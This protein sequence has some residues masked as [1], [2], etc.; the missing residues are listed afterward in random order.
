[1]KKYIAKTKAIRFE[2]NNYAGDWV[3]EAEKRGLPNL[4][5]T[6]AALESY[7]V[8]KNIKM[9]TSQNIL[10][11]VEIESRYNTKLEQYCNIIAIEYETL[12]TIV[13]TMVTPAALTY[14]NEVIKSV[15][16][17]KE[18]Q[19]LLDDTTIIKEQAKLLSNIAGE[20]SGL[21]KTSAVLDGLTKKA[22]GIEPE[23]EKAAYI[24]DKVIP[25]MND[26]RSHCD[27]LEELVPDDL[28]PLPKYR[29]MLF[30]M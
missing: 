30:I 13:S 21:S 8:A 9:L 18:V 25:A 11:E 27:L 26:V 17:L 29:E 19:D 16:G 3:K 28:W 4:K 10:S 15:Q 20:L 22:D 1:L 14:Q 5:N 23:K 2:G 7:R 12:K 6:P 24:A